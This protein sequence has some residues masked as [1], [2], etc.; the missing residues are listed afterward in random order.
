[1]FRPV[2]SRQCLPFLKNY[3]VSNYFVMNV[4]L[5]VAPLGSIPELAAESCQE[6]KA[7]RGQQVVSDRYWIH[8]AIQGKAILA[9]CDM[10][11]GGGVIN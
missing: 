11:T 5:S 1:M 6:I 4:S 8:S 7:S 10:E 3:S 9:Y 2:V